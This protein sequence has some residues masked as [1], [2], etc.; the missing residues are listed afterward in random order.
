LEAA[1]S[2]RFGRIAFAGEHASDE[3][4]L[5]GVLRSG[6]RAAGDLLEL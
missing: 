5:D 6:I 3:Q 4:T 1:L 2:A